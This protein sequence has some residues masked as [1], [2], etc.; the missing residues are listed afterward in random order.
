MSRATD[1]RRSE[2]LPT[3]GWCSANMRNVPSMNSALGLGASIFSSSAMRSSYSTPCDL[4]D[5]TARPLS[6]S[7]CLKST[8]LGS[9]SVASTSDTTL[10]A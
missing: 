5:A 8:A 3:H 10:S 2:S 9:S 4:S 7:T 6:V 1:L